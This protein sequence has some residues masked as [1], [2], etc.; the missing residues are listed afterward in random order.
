MDAVELDPV[1]IHVAE[2]YVKVDIKNCNLVH[3]DTRKW[4][5]IN[6]E[7]SYD[8]IIDDVFHEANKVPYRSIPVREI[9][10][11]KTE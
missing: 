6:K 1:H 3:T 10:L 4:V 11:K 9:W 7:C 8:L 5:N 2:D